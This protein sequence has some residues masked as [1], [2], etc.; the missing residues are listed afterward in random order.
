MY[1]IDRTNKDRTGRKADLEEAE[2]G[3]HSTDP[4]IRKNAY[5][6]GCRIAKESG[7]IRSMREALV[8]EHRKGNT[9]N[10]R[11]IHE[12]IKN[13]IEYINR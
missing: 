3:L 6:S 7:K 5:D 1:F 11:D 9:E 2:R 13:K 8:K 4:Q 10:V 12:Y